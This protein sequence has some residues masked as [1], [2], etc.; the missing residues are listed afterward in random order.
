MYCIQCGAQLARGARFCVECGAPAV[1]A[2]TNR[3]DARNGGEQMHRAE[4]PLLPPRDVGQIAR[5]WAEADR[6]PFRY[7]GSWWMRDTTGGAIRWNPAIEVW[8]PA[9]AAQTPFFMRRPE[10]SRSWTLTTWT[11]ILV[12]LT[13]LLSIG[14][15]IASLADAALIDDVLADGRISMSES[16]DLVQSENIQDGVIGLWALAYIPAI[17]LFIIWTRRV[18]AN[19]PSLG[20]EQPRFGKGWAVGG[21]FVPILNLWRPVQ[22]INQAWRSGSGARSDRHRTADEL[23]DESSSPL[24]YFWWIAFLAAGLLDRVAGIGLESDSL[25]EVRDAD[26]LV[27][28]SQAVL[29][30]AGLLA[31]TVM[32]KLVKRQNEAHDWLLDTPTEYQAAMDGFPGVAPGGAPRFRAQS[33]YQ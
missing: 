31:S 6:W 24:I 3:G 15:L 32:Y 7:E 27:A 28:V 2:S 26:Y 12:A 20:I 16:D 5:T 18:T 10:F 1:G 19:V 23:G 30:I 33:P 25:E 11:I 29:A 22:V 14:V 17:I 9:P 4:S 13:S 21:W 8:T